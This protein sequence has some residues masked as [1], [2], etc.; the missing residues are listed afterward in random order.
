MNSYTKITTNINQT[1]CIQTSENVHYPLLSTK[2][3]IFSSLKIQ[4]INLFGRSFVFQ[5]EFSLYKLPVYGTKQAI[6]GQ[7][8]KCII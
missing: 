3:K 7:Y 1:K 2:S 8:T 6:K 4:L 5:K